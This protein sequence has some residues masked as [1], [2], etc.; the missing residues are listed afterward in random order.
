MQNHARKAAV[1]LFAGAALAVG[2]LTPASAQPV[3]TGGLVNV[4]I[5]DAVDIEDVTV[6]AALGIAANLCGVGVNVLA[7]Q[8]SGPGPVTC[9]IEDSGQTVTI[10]PA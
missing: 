2:A 5:T 9:T 1:S 8:L 7:Q 6:G 10:E 3:I 4:V